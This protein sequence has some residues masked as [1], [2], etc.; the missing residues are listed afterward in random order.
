MRDRT[1]VIVGAGATAACG[2]PLTNDLLPLAFGAGTDSPC[3]QPIVSVGVRNA[4]DLS[5]ADQFLVETFEVPADHHRRRSSDYPALPIVLS[6]IDLALDRGQAFGKRWT[7]RRLRRARLGLECAIHAVL[8]VTLEP[9]ELADNPYVRLLEREFPP[10]GPPPVVVSLNYDTLADCALVEWHRRH[11][12]CHRLPHYGC[13]PETQVLDGPDER[14]GELY[15]LHGSLCW[16]FCTVCSRLRQRT[17]NLGQRLLRGIGVDVR[18]EDTTDTLFDH[19]PTCPDDHGECTRVLV[20]PTYRKDYRN[21]HLA[22]VWYAAEARLRE[23]SRLVFVG[24]SL[25]ESD[26]EVVYLL[27]RSC[28]QRQ[29]PAERITVVE[30]DPAGTALHVNV[31]GQRYESLF[32]TGV[33]WHTEGLDAWL[34]GAPSAPVR[35]AA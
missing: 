14:C 11:R 32:G 4:S 8:K 18:S 20:A 30:H 13:R 19:T 6:L 33:D 10:S 16:E 17:T 29:L 3:R 26:V 23:A 1:V 31:I 25:P 9:V 35:P 21:F 12:G 27:K 2:G 15:K 7:P 28:P 5:W 24:Y 22:H 34:A